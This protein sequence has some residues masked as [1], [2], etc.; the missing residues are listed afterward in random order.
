MDIDPIYDQCKEKLEA[1][2][3]KLTAT[4]RDLD[5]DDSELVDT[6]KGTLTEVTD[7]L[8]KL[9]S[10]TY[11][12]CEKCNRKIGFSRVYEMPAVRLC[13]DCAGEED[14]GATLT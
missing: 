8:G 1:L 5:G 6:L 14:D 2:R 3:A 12:Q 10:G 7:A 13:I 4:L 11:G 9:A